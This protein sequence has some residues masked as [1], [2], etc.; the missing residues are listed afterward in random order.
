MASRIA[1]CALLVMTLAPLAACAPRWSAPVG[2]QP[3][4][5]A[6]PGADY[7]HVWPDERTWP[8]SKVVTTRVPSRWTSF[9]AQDREG[10]GNRSAAET[11]WYLRSLHD[12]CHY[13]S[14]CRR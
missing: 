5:D 3:P 1:A 9:D 13:V 11:P 6:K 2:Y 14:G 10:Y 7:S 12:S 8:A 4:A